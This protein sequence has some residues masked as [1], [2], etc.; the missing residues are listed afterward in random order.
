M[1]FYVAALV[2]MSVMSPACGGGSGSSGQGGGSGQAGQAW[3]AGQGGGTGGVLVGTGGVVSTGGSGSPDA[4]VF[5]QDSAIAGGADVTAKDAPALDTAATGSEAGLEVP[6]LGLDAQA[7]DATAEDADPHGSASRWIE[8]GHQFAKCTWFSADVGY[9]SEAAKSLSA[10]STKGTDLYQTNN[11]GRA[12][13]LVA[14]IDGKN[15]STDSVMNVYVLS[16]AEIWYTTAFVGFGFS[17]T[18]GRSTNGGATWE[19]LTDRVDRAM[20]DDPEA[21]SPLSAPFFDLVQVGGALWLN[22]GTWSQYFAMSPD[23]GLTWKRVL[24]P[25]SLAEVQA[26]EFIATKN[27]LL[28]RYTTR[29]WGISLYRLSA[30]NFV[31]TEATFPA[32]SDVDHGNTWWRASSNGDGVTFADRRAWPFWGWPFLVSATLDGAKTFT[33][34]YAGT[35]QIQSGCEGLRDVLTFTQGTSPVT[36][37]SGIFLDSASKRFVEIRKSVAGG[38]TWTVL[39]SEPAVGNMTSVA[40]DPT[41]KVHAMRHTSD[42]Y[43]NTY[44]YDAQYVLE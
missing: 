6:T 34:V 38:N 13:T 31:A 8:F 11:G 5:P 40:L 43:G 30:G 2:S 3:Q 24:G 29:S 14:T 25:L 9:C 7:G 44:V 1:K 33:T 39:H 18:I 26:P 28:L 37:I 42:N 10:T 35:S 20:A 23:K 22:T 12:W 15:T 16:P 4:A 21:G 36:Y 17:G 27:D 32:P 19:S 41:G